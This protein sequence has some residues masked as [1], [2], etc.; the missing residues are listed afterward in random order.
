MT[1]SAINSGQFCTVMHDAFNL[2]DWVNVDNNMYSQQQQADRFHEP[3]A[4]R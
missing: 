4:K 2:Q 1:V 3:T